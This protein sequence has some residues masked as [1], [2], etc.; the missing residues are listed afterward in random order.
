MRKKKNSKFLTSLLV[1][2]LMFAVSISAYAAN[3]AV[4]EVHVSD[5]QVVLYVPGDYDSSD[6]SFQ[7]GQTPCTVVSTKKISETSNKIHTIILVDNSL[8]VMGS[9]KDK[10]V[11]SLLE[12]MISNRADGELF[13]I[14]ILGDSVDF[15]VVDSNDY[16]SIKSAVGNIVAEK[17]SSLVVEN[18]NSIVDD[19]NNSGTEDFYRMVVIS[20]GVDTSIA[21][22]TLEEL[23][24]KL[25]A[26]PYPIYT[27]GSGDSSADN[28]KN[29]FSISRAANTSFFSLGET[30]AEDILST[31]HNDSNIIQVVASIPDEVKDGSVKSAMLTVGGASYECSVK[32]PFALESAS[33]TVEEAAVSQDSISANQ[34][35]PVTVSNNV[36]P[37]TP[38]KGFSGGITIMIIVVLCLA[39]ALIV[40]LL[41]SKSKKKK[42][43]EKKSSAK[44]YDLYEQMDN[45]EDD[46]KTIS[47]LNNPIPSKKEDDEYIDEDDEKTVMIMGGPAP[48]FIVVQNASDKDEVY[49]VSLK[50][51]ITVG[52][53][54]S[55]NITIKNNKAASGHHCDL[56]M[57]GDDLYIEDA[58]S[59]NGTKISGRKISEPTKIESG[60]VVTIGYDDYIITINE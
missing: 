10:A 13:S 29:M 56:Y 28:I 40:V 57:K 25:T 9:G 54:S 30:S 60:A 21:G 16:V 12:E 53:G 20:D 52:R 6:C 44:V 31:I 58:G 33:S 45:M 48:K 42:Q 14:G 38:N 5:D 24:T 11:H 49:S 26:T 27:I 15:Q 8:S 37:A 1:V 4:S 7:I 17:K 59:S 51:T 36:I 35:K 50:G 18:I 3:A 2:V 34:P 46:G 22:V 39:V 43:L 19:I 41:V 32:M 23:V 47:I 55:N